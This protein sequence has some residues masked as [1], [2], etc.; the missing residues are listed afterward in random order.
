MKPEIQYLNN[1]PE[2][3]KNQNFSNRAINLKSNVSKIVAQ[4]CRVAK[5]LSY[6]L[7]VKVMQDNRAFSLLFILKSRRKTVDRNEKHKNQF[8]HKSC[9]CN[10]QIQSDSLPVTFKTV[11][12]GSHFTWA[13]NGLRYD[14]VAD[15]GLLPCRTTPKL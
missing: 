8:C 6:F 1:Q 15:C 2:N 14:L 10:G 9:R 7:I 13:F 11:V 5:A 4:I 12:I 3:H